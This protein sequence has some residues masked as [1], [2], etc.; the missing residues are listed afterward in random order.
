[1]LTSR[2][3][4]VGLDMVVEPDCA[5]LPFGEDIRLRWQGAERRALRTF[6]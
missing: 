4:V 5:L 6:A 2:S 1:M 3:F